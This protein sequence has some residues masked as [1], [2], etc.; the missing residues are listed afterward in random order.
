MDANSLPPDF[1]TIHSASEADTDEPGS[2]S[3]TDEFAGSLPSIDGYGTVKVLGRGGMGVVILANDESLGRKVAIK[4]VSQGLVGSKSLRDRFDSEVKVLASLHHPNIAQL[5]TASTHDQTPFFVMEYVEG[6]TLD[7]HAREPMTSPA[8]AALVKTLA[9][10]IN[11]CHQQG[12]LHRD[13]KPSNILMT[14]DQVPKIAD[15]GLA[16]TVE[17]DTSSTKTGEILGTPGYMSPEQAG[18]IVKNLGPPC[19][20]YGLGAILYRLITGRAPFAA[21]EAFQAVIMVLSDD[22]IRPR[23]LVPNVDRELETIC[24]KCLEKKPANRYQTA[25][26]LQADLGRFLAGEPI[27]AKPAGWIT[28]AVKWSKR[29]LA[30]SVGI[31]ATLVLVLLGIIGLAL[32]NSTLARELDRSKRLADHGS[33]FAMWI[34]ENHLK[35]LNR[36]P[37][38][39]KSR[40]RLVNEV[41]QFLEE[42]Y[43]D[44]PDDPIYTQ[45]LGNSYAQLAANIGGVR[46]NTVG[47]LEQAESSY[48]RAIELYDVTLKSISDPQRTLRLKIDALIELADVQLWLEKPQLRRE[49]LE[50]A[51]SMLGQ[52]SDQTW[53]KYYGIQLES[54]KISLKMES[55][56]HKEAELQLKDLESRI[57]ELED[58]G[59]FAEEMA[60]QRILLA[61][62]RGLCAENLGNLDE[63]KGYLAEA[64]K[65]SRRAAAED[66]DNVA[67]QTRLTQSLTRLADTVFAQQEYE[68]AKKLYEE[69][70]TIAETLAN[71]DE[72]SVDAKIDFAGRLSRVAGVYQ[73]MSLFADAEIAIAKAIRIL[74]K[75]SDQ[76]SQ[77]RAVD[78][79]LMIYTQSHASLCFLQ[80][81]YADS[82]KL[83][84]RHEELCKTELKEDSK[85]VFVL[86]QMAEN[87]LTRALMNLSQWASKQWTPET[88]DQS[89]GLKLID[90]NLKASREYYDRIKAIQPLNFHQESQLERLTQ[91]RQVTDNAVQQI[92]QTAQSQQSEDKQPDF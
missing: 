11:Y 45:R 73:N 70:L 46:Q 22:P 14:T 31:A 76:G 18:G 13:L 92:K 71:K 9:E 84:D 7:E 1:E 35:A 41:K 52:L 38:T 37:G 53:I 8:A 10:A 5:Y 72:D 23:K 88:V 80:G 79:G 24:L 20:V 44:M 12:V 60:N 61:S 63:A 83:F 90:E 48:Q 17:G 27:L 77:D 54:R 28:R 15:F 4:L 59:E 50:R 74:Q 69:S 42:S 58:S 25:E 21:A 47:D 89:P 43:D 19:D 67:N 86:N 57:I 6:T 2:H 65:L 40:T 75:L 32:H 55:N 51:E 29:N 62:R 26:E 36:L 91:I 56:Q 16:K 87:R 82:K 39:T 34:T 3:A 66:P 81:K 49:S 78:R 30:A 68:L 33:E 85:A 64:V